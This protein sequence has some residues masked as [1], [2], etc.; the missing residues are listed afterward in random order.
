MEGSPETSSS[1]QTGDLT[2]TFNPLPSI[3]LFGSYTINAQ[4]NRKTQ[5]ARSIGGSWSPFRGGALLLNTSYRE[6]IDNSGNKDSA[7]VQS[8]RWN[9]RSG[10]FLDLSYL[11]SKDATATRTTNTQVFNTAMRLSF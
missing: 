1:T 11:V 7:I 3:Y 8:L 2:V 9:I 4:T 5:T 6:N 10:W